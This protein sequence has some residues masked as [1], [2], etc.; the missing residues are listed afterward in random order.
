MSRWCRN[1]PVARFG[2]G[3]ALVLSVFIL[4]GC[5]EHVV[6]V[7]G[8]SARTVDVYE[9]NLKESENPAIKAIEDAI[10]GPPQTKKSAGR[11]GRE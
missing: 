9:P 8:P 11:S 7:E 10:F 4:A 5:Y 2:R 6:R 1:L 3:S